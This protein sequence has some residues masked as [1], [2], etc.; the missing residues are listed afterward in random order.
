MN[1]DNMIAERDSLKAETRTILDKAQA[2]KRSLSADES[3][4]VADKQAKLRELVEMCDAEA[5][6][7]ELELR[8][9]N[10][11]AQTPESKSVFADLAEKRAMALSTSGQQG[12]SAS[13]FADAPKHAQILSRVT[14]EYGALPNQQ[15]P[16]ITS[17]TNINAVDEDGTKSAASGSAFSPVLVTP[18]A[19]LGYVTLTSWLL[20]NYPAIESKFRNAVPAW[21]AA[22]MA[23]MTVDGLFAKAGVHETDC[24]AAGA[25]TLADAR[26]CIS[27]LV[28]R[29]PRSL[30]TLVAN[31]TYVNAWRS[32][33]T[34][35]AQIE[36]DAQR[37]GD[38]IDGVLV[39]EE[40]NALTD[41]TDGNPLIVCGA[42]GNYGIAVADPMEFEL[43]GK[44][45][46]SENI[47]AQFC[48]WFGGDVVTTG[49]FERMV[50]K[51]AG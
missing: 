51:A 39:I 5:R 9:S 1:I 32:G 43:L 24:A 2:E 37:G 49:S 12:F 48:L 46:G 25:P 19:H 30:L 10:I 50:A 26:T 29:F 23:K 21:M 4:L 36:Y 40:D 20:R 35:G 31:P 18:T 11:K 6:Q 28:G 7:T 27:K 15:F 17:I 42:L 33:D 8:A 13:F 44:I 45:A 47:P 38:S 3:K 41:T 16:L 14:M 22:L 34:Y